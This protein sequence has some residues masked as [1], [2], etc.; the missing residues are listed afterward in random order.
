MKIGPFAAF[1]ATAIGV[2]AY[3][4]HKMDN[5]IQ[6]K[7]LENAKLS[8]LILSQFYEYDDNLNPT[9]EA[10]EK[11][12]PPSYVSLYPNLEY[13]DFTLYQRPSAPPVGE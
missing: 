6:E 4:F 9:S 1:V 3:V 12:S 13:P 8:K 10:S 7:D 2:A 11:E 5:S